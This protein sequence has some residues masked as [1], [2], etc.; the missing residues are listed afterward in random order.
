MTDEQI[1]DRVRGGETRLFGDLVRRYQDLVFGMALRLV[2]TVSDAEDVAQEAFLRVHRGL[3]GFKGDAK[4]STWLYRITYNLC[5]DWQRKNRARTVRAGAIEE[6]EEIADD[7]V[8]L[9][10]GLLD[11][12]ERTRVRRALDDLEEK[13][14]CVVVLH[15]YQK[16]PYE[17]IAVVLDVPLKTVETR[18]YRARKKL[19]ECLEK[20]M[21]GGAR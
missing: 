19:R 18:L 5:T 16:L 4:F 21:Q 14:R 20:G 10:Q 3:E 11:A 15:Y 8:H 2:G 17:Q 12:E 9:E 6:A 13:Y 7:R 1:I